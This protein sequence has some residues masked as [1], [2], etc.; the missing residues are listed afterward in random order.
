VARENALV[1]TLK[2]ERVA[3]DCLGQTA[4]TRPRVR[5]RG[6]T[7]KRGHVRNPEANDSIDL[8]QRAFNGDGAAYADPLDADR[9][10]S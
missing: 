1:W 7:S 2:V 3:L 5:S 4:A 8:N 9:A 6:L 10:A